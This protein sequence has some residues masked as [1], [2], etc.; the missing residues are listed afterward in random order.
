M[1]IADYLVTNAT[2]I[3]LREVPVK[4][5]ETSDRQIREL[6]EERRRHVEIVA[7][8]AWAFVGHNSLHG[9]TLDCRM[10]WY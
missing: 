2:N 1:W 9:L 3:L 10:N 5:A 6:S 7:D 4:T 8:A